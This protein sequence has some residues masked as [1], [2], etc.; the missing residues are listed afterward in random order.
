V[1][2]QAAGT[3][4]VAR[5]RRVQSLRI[6]VIVVVRLFNLLHLEVGEVEQVR[7]HLHGLVTFSLPCV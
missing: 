2:D 5:A 4:M 7:G 3:A 6:D 1:A